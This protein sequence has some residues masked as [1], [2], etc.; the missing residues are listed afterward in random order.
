MSGNLYIVATPIGNLQDIAPRGLAALCAV[1]TILAEDTRQAKKLL[2]H[3]SIHAPLERFD[4][5]A[6][7][8]AI[9]RA[10]ERLRAGESL[11]LITDAGT[12]AISDPG[13]WLVSEASRELGAELKVIPIPGPSSVTAALSV[14]GFPADSF[15]FFGF[16]PPK[17]GR[18]AQISE[19]AACTRTAVFFESPYR[20]GKTLNDLR[21]VCP[22]RRA[23]ICRELTKMFETIYRGTL[24]E[25]SRPGVVREQGEFVVVLEPAK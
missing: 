11:A 14:A 22:E 17:K 16:L 10:I 3:F 6:D 18:T 7:H 9:I 21:A 2:A 24:A 8:R 4:A 23:V 5:H 25:L 12:P 19:I 1:S 15:I 13:S 20:I